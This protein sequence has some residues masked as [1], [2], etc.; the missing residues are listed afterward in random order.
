L[1]RLRI[2]RFGDAR[3]R[4]IR[5]SKRSMIVG[6]GVSNCCT[7]RHVMRA[8]L[9]GG[10]VLALACGTTAPTPMR[11]LALGDSY[12]IGE[13]VPAD[14]RWPI[15]LSLALRAKQIYCCEPKIVAKTVW[16]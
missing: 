15:Q 12:T 2:H 13:S 6:G 3:G 1:P 11:F 14:Q 5:T 7:L 16:S 4:P 9:L 8:A 10:L